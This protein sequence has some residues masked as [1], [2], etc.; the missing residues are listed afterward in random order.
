MMTLAY[1]NIE[2][3]V[4]SDLRNRAAHTDLTKASKP[5]VCSWSLFAG[6]ETK[7]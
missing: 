4:A 6:Q 3:I 7:T 5:S 2:P 1:L